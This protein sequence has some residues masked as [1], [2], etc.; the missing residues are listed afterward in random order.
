M[1]RRKFL[2]YAAVSGL[3]ILG[4]GYLYKYAAT[5]DRENNFLSTAEAARN[6]TMRSL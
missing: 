6:M 3:G 5:T 4:G 1:Q 2:T